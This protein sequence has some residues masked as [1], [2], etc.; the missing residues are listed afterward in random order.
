MNIQTQLLRA[1]DFLADNNLVWSD[2]LESIRKPLSATLRALSIHLTV[3]ELSFI[4]PTVG[5]LCSMIL[6]G[7][8]DLTIPSP[9]EE[10]KQQRG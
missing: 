7:E 3:K 5:R 8:D 9:I 1:S 10:Y 4:E 2:D 6:D